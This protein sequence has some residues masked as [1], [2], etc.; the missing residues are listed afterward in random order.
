M[1]A[2]PSE[3]DLPDDLSRLR[4]LEES[5]VR[6]ALRSRFDRSK[7]YT[8][9]NSLLVAMNPYRLLPLYAEPMLDSY[10]RYGQ[11]SPGPHVFGVA[12][13]AY[14]GLLDARSQSVII[15]GESGVQGVSGSV[16]MSP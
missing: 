13:S 15:S 3:D 6:G 9:I 16:C 10:S 5:A 8:H 2:P 14:R 1:L 7:I 4:S 12:A 11:A